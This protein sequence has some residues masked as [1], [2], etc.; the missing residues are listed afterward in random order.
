MKNSFTLEI[1][2]EE[3]KDEIIEFI[4]EDENG[5]TDMVNCLGPFIDGNG[6]IK[7]MY[8]QWVEDFL[9]LSKK[10]PDI[11]F[12]VIRTNIDN[13]KDTEYGYF[14]ANKYYTEFPNVLVNDFDERKLV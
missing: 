10:F 5:L 6:G 7:F 11:L 4:N 1:S 8:I 3:R 12:T 13:F 14:R 2:D 9:F